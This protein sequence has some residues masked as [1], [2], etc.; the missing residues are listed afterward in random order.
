VCHQILEQPGKTINAL[1]ITGKTIFAGT[2][3][4]IFVS[5]N[6]GTSWSSFS[7]GLMYTEI[8]SLLLSG[9]YLFTRTA[10]GGIWRRPLSKVTAVKD[11]SVVMPVGWSFAQNYP[12]PFKPSTT[13]LFTIPA[14]SF[15]TLKVFD[16]MG[17]DVVTLVQGELAAGLHTRV[18]S[19]EYLSSG[20]YCYRMQAG[21]ISETKKFIILR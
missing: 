17:R 13:I 6:G 15:V 10:T 5:T 8:R 16:M 2:G 4:G 12:N 9:Q 19:S 7:T 14:R 18:L 11:V 21:A 1:A 20:V 3:K